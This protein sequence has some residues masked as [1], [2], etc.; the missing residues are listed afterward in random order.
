MSQINV[1]V[2]S[3]ISVEAVTGS[4]YTVITTTPTAIALT[5]S[6]SAGPIGLTGATGAT[7]PTGATGDTG[8]T[9]ESIVGPTGETGLTGSTGPTGM[10][11]ATGLTGPTGETGL[12]GA[13]GQTGLTGATGPTGVTGS[14]GATGTAGIGIPA[15]GASGYVLTKASDADYDTTWAVGG[16][17]GGYVA[18]YDTSIAFSTQS[19]LQ[20]V[21]VTTATAITSTQVITVRYLT[22]HEDLTLQ[23]VDI[24]EYSRSAES[25][26]TVIAIAPQG[27]SGT[28]SIRC[29][30]SGV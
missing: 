10:T 22:G 2:P 29:I 3:Q 17:S 16:G 5:V 25:S 8:A 7:G 26:F 30:V 9:G 21:A 15:S 24:R 13:T 23:N 11:G 12:T 27:A 14:T 6:N 20:T 19:Q 1:L 18:S 4:T 28:Y